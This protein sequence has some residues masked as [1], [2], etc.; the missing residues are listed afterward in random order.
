MVRGLI[1]FCLKTI[2]SFVYRNKQHKSVS[3]FI[4][5]GEYRMGRKIGLIFLMGLLLAGASTAEV[6]TPVLWGMVG[7]IV[8][9]LIIIA[10]SEQTQQ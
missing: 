7:L 4:G 8:F 1:F 5:S 2:Q 3:L 10:T 9:A 6:A